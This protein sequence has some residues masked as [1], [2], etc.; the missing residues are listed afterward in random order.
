MDPVLSMEGHSDSIQMLSA[1]KVPPLSTFLHLQ[2]PEGMNNTFENPTKP[3]WPLPS[4][5]IH[6]KDVHPREHFQPGSSKSG[7]PREW[8]RGARRGRLE[9][10]AAGLRSGKGLPSHQDGLGL[11]PEP[12]GKA[13]FSWES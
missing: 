3:V 8:E 10:T 11:S 6:P 4:L 7:E 2:F 9:A 12:T 13:E 1:S 5:P